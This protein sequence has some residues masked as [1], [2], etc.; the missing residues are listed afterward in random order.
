MAKPREV[1]IR[2]IKVTSTATPSPRQAEVL[3]LF[4][5]RRQIYAPM[6]TYAELCDLLGVASTNAVACHIRALIA[7]G[8]LKQYPG[9]RT[10]VARPARHIYP[11]GRAIRWMKSLTV[12]VPIMTVVDGQ[13]VPESR[14][15]RHQVAQ[16]SEG[17]IP[18][19]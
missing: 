1:P 5:F 13:L 10:A 15:R 2:E 8:Y 19:E 17:R 7:K 9:K 12:A 6:P 18:S 4:C 3:S 11:T 16:K 14:K